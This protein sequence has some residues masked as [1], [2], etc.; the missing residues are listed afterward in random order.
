MQIYDYMAARA[1]SEGLKHKLP[2]KQ[3]EQWVKQGSRLFF[4][5][6]VDAFGTPML[7]EQNPKVFGEWINSRKRDQ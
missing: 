1:K 2:R 3:F 4:G 5:V 7:D 6:Q